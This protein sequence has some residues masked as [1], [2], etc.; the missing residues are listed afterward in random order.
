MS[1]RSDEARARGM[2]LGETVETWDHELGVLTVAMRIIP[3]YGEGET[4]DAAIESLLDA[5]VDYCSVYQEHREAW[6]Q[7]DPPEIQ[8][9]LDTLIGCSGDRQALRKALDLRPHP[10]L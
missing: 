3:A 10:R 9:L 6:S 4:R 5:V 2:P 7:L 1:E 8:K